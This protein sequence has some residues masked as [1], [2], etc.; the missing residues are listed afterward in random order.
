L[1]SFPRHGPSAVLLVLLVLLVPVARADDG[2]ALWVVE[3][4]DSTLYLF[5][6]IHML[7]SDLVWFDG[8]VRS[9]F[10]ASD[11]LWL[12]LDDPHRTRG[13]PQLVAA[14]GYDADGSLSARLGPRRRRALDEGGRSL[15]LD[16]A[17]IDT[18]R[19][20]LAAIT[21]STAPLMQHGVDPDAGADNVL[22]DAAQASGKPVRGFETLEQ[23]LRFLAEL[24]DEAQLAFLGDTL[25]HLRHAW[26]ELE[27][28][29][30]AWSRADLRWLTRHVTELTRRRQPEL[31]DRLLARRNVAW[32]DVLARRLDGSGTSF[33]AVGA[34]HLLG[35]DGVPALLAARGL[36][37]RRL[38]PATDP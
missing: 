23:Q 5:G 25:D 21:L 34:G 37:V 17:Q 9:A 2:P 4:A 22:L 12:E 16:A 20:W 28:L 10:E 18:M 8:P 19:P 11:E 1:P 13:V 6:T 3:D 15:G 33:V 27:R 7:P 24:S 32:A 36:H 35:A 38:R 26:R 29:A 14:L 30:D 31:H